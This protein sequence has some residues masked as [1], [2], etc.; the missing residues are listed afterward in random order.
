MR[1]SIPLVLA[2][3]AGFGALAWS[4]ASRADDKAKAKTPLVT[5]DD[6]VRPILRE[7]CFSCHN[8][9][10]T[11]GGL[12]LDSYAAAM[13]GG[14]SGE[15]LLAED[16]D[17]SRLWALIT[18]A[19]EP[20]MPPMQEKL[21]QAKL[22]VIRNWIMS[23][24]RENSGSKAVKRK[25]S[26]ALAMVAAGG[27]KPK[28]PAAMP[29]D[30]LRQPVVYTERAGA[31]SAMAAS[32]WAPLVAVAGHRQVVLYHTETGKCLGVLP[33]PEGV[34]YV[35]R[36]SR[37]GEVLLVG[38]GRGGH[39]GCVALYDVR[40]G[41][42]ITKIGDELDAVL[43][44]DIN[45]DM[46]KVALGGPQRIVRI[47]STE[48]G[49]LLHEIRKHTD[50]VLAVRFSPDGVLLAT[51]DRS[52]GLFV[53]E[54]DTA[55]EYLDLRGHSGPIWEVA[56]RPDSNVLASAGQDGTVRLWEL[57]DGKEIKRFGAHRGGV[58]W[59][60]YGQDGRIVTAGSDKTVK[61]WQGDGKAIAAFSGYSEPTL[62]AVL[63]H[64]GKR[65]IGGDWSGAVKL[66][67]TTT[68]K[69][70]AEL[71]PNPPTLE[72]RLEQARA[73]HR[74]AENNLKAALAAQA[75]AQAAHQ[76]VTARQTRLNDA[77]KQL[78]AKQQTVNRQLVEARKGVEA[79][80]KMAAKVRQAMA[81]AK[82]DVAA[83]TQA[84]QA[85][86][87]ELTR[88]E[89]QLAALQQGKPQSEQQKKAHDIKLKELTAAK[90]A[91]AAAK[92]AAQQA[93]AAAQQT[94]TKQ[95]RQ[96]PE[97]DKKV[98]DLTELIG[99]LQAQQ[100]QFPARIAAA[101][102][103]AKQYAA[104]VAASAKAL[105]AKQAAAAQAKQ[106][107]AAS[108]AEIDAAQKELARFEAL[109]NSL[110]AEV[111]SLEQSLSKLQAQRDATARKVERLADM[112]AQAEKQIA[113][114]AAQLKQ[115]QTRLAELQ[116][117]KDASQQQWTA[118]RRQA[119]KLEAT[120]EDA[121]F[122]LQEAVERR[123]F[124]EQAY[125]RYWKSKPTKTTQTGSTATSVA[126]N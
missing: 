103:A 87:A 118:M 18:H 123:T 54:A 65:V 50:W 126:D 19:E 14:S 104:Q 114:V 46:T 124:F 120:L 82:Q 102:K 39:S 109:K 61:L 47:Y 85:A 78:Q 38:G 93:L 24:L 59:V 106:A 40:T 98:P 108:S 83:K 37:N 75:Q 27:G 111:A 6:H 68:R 86:A 95:T 53:W 11:K 17:S 13:E 25:K 64:D 56:W 51:A 81:R 26:T 32:P 89:K 121:Q 36:F 117:E 88:I 7:H 90:Q 94:L 35:L 70:I 119:E 3:A 96:L 2:V 80:K 8:R 15:V 100:K 33:F 113:A 122:K 107:V 34:P 21:P 52:N 72:L 84:A 1:H 125:G 29:K 9:D 45:D 43:S 69:P 101:Q 10:R 105:A 44:A 22:D 76:A 48:T 55:R 92:T 71:P 12:A 49:E 4:E 74:Q 115:L 28:G 31:V 112:K 30:V 66:L 20:A 110:D 42:R 77:V 79:A 73:A 41:K 23:G 63:S 91:A 16:L 116:K 99:N 97:L 5:Y 67:D 57:N 62:K 58:S 60:A